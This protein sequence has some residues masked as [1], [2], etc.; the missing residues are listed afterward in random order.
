MNVEWSQFRVGN[1]PPVTTLLALIYA[2]VTRD[3]QLMAKTVPTLM[4]VRWVCTVVLRIHT[5]WITKEVTRVPATKD[6][7]VNGLSP[8]DDVPNVTR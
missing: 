8:T 6:G 1:T 3:G 4:S 5:A 7:N 2:S